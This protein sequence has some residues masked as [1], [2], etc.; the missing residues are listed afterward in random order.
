MDEDF[1]EVHGCVTW[2]GKRY[3]KGGMWGSYDFKVVA[4]KSG[5]M[6]WVK[7]DKLYSVESE[8]TIYVCGYIHKDVDPDTNQP[9]YRMEPTDSPV[10]EPRVSRVA[11]VKVFINSMYIVKGVKFSLKQEK[12]SR[13]Y[14]HLAEITSDM[15]EYE[16]LDEPHRVNQHMTKLANLAVESGNAGRETAIADLLS[17]FGGEQT[18]NADQE[19][20]NLL[21]FWYKERELRKLLMLG[22]TEKEIKKS[23]YSTDVLY[24]KVRSNPF[25][26]PI[27]DQSRAVELMERFGIVPSDM[28]MNC[29]EIIRELYKNVT[30][31]GW[32][33]TPFNVLHKKF[34]NLGQFIPELTAEVDSDGETEY[35]Y[36]IRVVKYENIDYLYFRLDYEAERLVFDRLSEILGQPIN[37]MVDPIRFRKTL[38]DDQKTA[39]DGIL[40]WP[41]SVLTGGG[42]TGK[43]ATITEVVKNLIVRKA[44]FGVVSFTGKAVSRV[45][46]EM[47]KAKVSDFYRLSRTMTMHRAIYKGLPCPDDKLTHLI[48]DEASMVTTKLMAQFMKRFTNLQWILLVGDCNQLLPIEWGCLFKEIIESGTVPVYRLTEVHRVV[49][50]K[51]MKDGITKACQTIAE[52]PADSYPIFDETD[53]F[54]FLKGDE[55]A[56]LSLLNDLNSAGIT[57]SEMTIVTPYNKSVAVINTYMQSLYREGAEEAIDTSKKK[58]KVGDRVIML[59]NNYEINVMN[60][61]EGRIVGIQRGEHGKTGFLEVAFDDGE[62]NNPIKLSTPEDIQNFL[63]R[64]RGTNRIHRF[65]LSSSVREGE[66]FFSRKPNVGMLQLGYSVTIHKSQGSE[67][68]FSILYIPPESKP[69]RAFVNRNLLYTGASRGKKCLR[70]CGNI[71]TF[72]EGC[73]LRPAHRHELLGKWMKQAL[74]AASAGLDGRSLVIGVFSPEEEKYAYA[75]D[76]DDFDDFF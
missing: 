72:V 63:K 36:D 59:E 4:P 66:S 25:T 49:K 64:F 41:V 61:D 57:D 12:A 48:I 44:M 33:C 28:Q 74:P 15:E 40:T 70:I 62:E 38:S 21:F 7:S 26:V 19:A 24:R 65:S 67:W 69:S 58:W 76:D 37:T 22:L 73:I 13:I 47:R 32:S 30:E 54:Q 51:G 10:I 23:P 27:M 60:G 45:K 34:S 35:G 20:V 52:A 55:N 6:F 5:T 31:K 8:D 43:T 56:L 11:I 68:D 29:G 16:E 3:K 42:G 50:M 1:A 2:V 53:N 71:N 46:Q 18:P 75:M 39:I 14:D 17:P 9:I